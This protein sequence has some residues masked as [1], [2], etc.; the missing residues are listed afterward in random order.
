MALQYFARSLRAVRLRSVHLVAVAAVAG[1][2]ACQPM[3]GGGAGT[4]TQTLQVVET[5]TGTIV[6]MQQVAMPASG[7]SR[8]GGAFSGAIVGGLIGNQFGGGRGND[9]MTVIGAL[10]G[11]AA[12]N[13]LAQQ[14]NQQMIPQWTV[15]L[16]N[17]QTVAVQSNAPGLQVGG[18]ARVQRLSNGE[19]RIGPL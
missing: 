4:G 1:L 6:D 18:R 10:G 15:R 9:A 14:T 5:Q 12:G 16:D 7:L 13:A 2:A 3:T 8:A 17:G 11:A 19:L